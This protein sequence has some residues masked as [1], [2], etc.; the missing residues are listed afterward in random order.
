MRRMFIAAVLAAMLVVGMV[1]FAAG[2][3]TSPSPPF[4]QD[5]DRISW[6]IGG[7]NLNVPPNARSA[8]WLNEDL[9]GT[10]PGGYTK[11][12]HPNDPGD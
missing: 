8:L 4:D 2:Q 3:A 11:I 6:C 5:D 9:P 12:D 7:T 10:C 1:G